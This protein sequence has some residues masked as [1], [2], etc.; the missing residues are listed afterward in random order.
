MRVGTHD[1]VALDAAL[2]PDLEK[3]GDRLVRYTVCAAE[4]A[5][6]GECDLH[7]AG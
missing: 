5:Q 7:N 3:L 4:V 1:L 6:L 2:L